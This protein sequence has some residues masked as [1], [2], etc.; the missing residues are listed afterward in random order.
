MS[1]CLND[2]EALALISRMPAG[3]CPLFKGKIDKNARGCWRWTGPVNRA[4]YGILV[5]NNYRMLA[6]RFSYLFAGRH[7]IGDL[8]VLH[9][10]DN[11]PCVN[12]DHLFKGTQQDNLDDC[13][14]KDRHCRGT[15]QWKAKLTDAGVLKIRRLHREGVLARKMA[16][17]FGVTSATIR[18]AITGKKWAHL[19]GACPLGPRGGENSKARLTEKQVLAI[20]AARGTGVRA[21]ALAR[22]Y[23]V[24][25]G[26]IYVIWEEKRW[27]RLWK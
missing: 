5:F 4:G 16:L 23:G 7:P 18:E 20:H 19:P 25:T 22:K 14:S 24:C 10:C 26:T 8:F 9:K 6:H 13:K 2:D 17:M 15:R 12:P 1:K 21:A 11:P 27:P 3:Y